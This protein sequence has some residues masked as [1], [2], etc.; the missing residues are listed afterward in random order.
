MMVMSFA[1]CATTSA[2]AATEEATAAPEAAATTE[3]AAAPAIHVA[4][5]AKNTMD[6][7]HATLN[8][9]A[10]VALDAMVADG[11]IAGGMVPKVPSGGLQASAWPSL[12]MANRPW[13]GRGGGSNWIEM[14]GKASPRKNQGGSE[15]FEME[16]KS[17]PI[18]KS[19]GGGKMS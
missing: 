9:A 2:P 1:A 13:G 8:G 3:T 17:I 12:S 6:A 14:E 16:E 18:H 5:I 19:G 15:W 10:K 7:F 11:T 4:Y